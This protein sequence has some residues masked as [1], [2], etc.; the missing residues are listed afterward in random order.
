MEP[1][2]LSPQAR[3]SRGEPPDPD[4]GA[5]QQYSTL[6]I[7]ALM[8]VVFYFLI[9]RPQKKRQRAIADTLSSLTPGTRVL[10]GS[11]IFGTVVSVGAKQT[12]IETSPGVEVTVLKQ[13]IARVVTEAD[14]DAP[15][16]D[17]D[18]DDAESQFDSYPTNAAAPSPEVVAPEPT[19][20]GSSL[21]DRGSAAESGAPTVDPQ[22]PTGN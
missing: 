14:E 2:L 20:E 18:L 19:V 21:R 3:R 9:M 16:E 8:V 4:P 1:S 15:D 7:I 12:V 13:A 11:G 6:I 17:D 5:M 22:R 10:L